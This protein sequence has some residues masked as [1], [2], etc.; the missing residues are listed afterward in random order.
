MNAVKYSDLS[1]LVCPITHELPTR[2]VVAQDG[3]VY[4]EAAWMTYI[5]PKKRCKTVKSPWTMKT[6][7]KDVYFSAPIRQV[8]EK[9][10]RD[11]QV[12][13]DLHPAWKMKIQEENEIDKLKKDMKKNA[14]LAMVLGDHYYHGSCGVSK[15]VDVAYGYYEKGYFRIN[16]PQLKQEFYVKM[17]LSTASRPSRT[18]TDMICIWSS[19]CQIIHIDLVSYTVHTIM[20]K[21]EDDCQYQ[22]V[23]L[24]GLLHNRG[25]KK[26]LSISN[27]TPESVLMATDC[28]KQLASFLKENADGSFKSDVES[29]SDSESE[30]IENETTSE[31]EST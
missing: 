11:G 16:H 29:D 8:I 4:D 13:K 27:M 9:A 21:L 1:D 14:M 23:K 7:S 17:L 22:V 20:A 18:R 12:S 19:L 6:I 24:S 28:A 2:P 30:S 25:Y 3:K 10:V 26:G 5:K 31:S 15:D